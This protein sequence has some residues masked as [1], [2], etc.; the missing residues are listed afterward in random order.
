MHRM[1]NAEKWRRARTN[2]QVGRPT[3]GVC[4]DDL[5]PGLDVCIPHV[6]HQCEALA[7]GGLAAESVYAEPW[8]R[9]HG[10]QPRHPARAARQAPPLVEV[11]PGGP[12]IA[13]ALSGC[14]TPRRYLLVR[15]Q[16]K[17]APGAGPRLAHRLDGAAL[18]HS[19]GFCG[20]VNPG[21]ALIIHA[22]RWLPRSVP[23]I[24]ATAEILASGYDCGP[25]GGPGA[26]G[27]HRPRG[28]FHRSQ[29]RVRAGQQVS[30]SAQIRCQARVIASVQGQ[31]AANF[32]RRRRPPRTR[33]A[34]AF[35]TR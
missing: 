25:A 29:G 16:C 33:R 27:F 14:R 28:S 34:A 12:V 3:P 13:S 21:L 20:E 6:D 5:L 4:G 1:R 31:F 35:R 26:G 11:Q 24:A 15:G 9:T 18:W 30:G 23:R 7:R 22:G 32:Q 19:C 17:A 8:L 10:G 2:A